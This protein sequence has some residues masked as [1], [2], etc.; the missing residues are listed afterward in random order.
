MCPVRVTVLLADAAQSSPDGK[1]HVLGLGWT[2]TSAPTPPMALVVL[3]DVDQPESNRQVPCRIDL[4]DED[5]NEVRLLGPDGQARPVSMTFGVQI[6]RP[7]GYPEGVPVRVVSSVQVP[8]MPLPAGRRFQWRVL[9]DGETI[10]P[11][12]TAFGTRNDPPGPPPA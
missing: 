3:L 12:T 6:T 1:A 2:F 10:M 8:P 5:G 11:W 4:V 7:S 9:V